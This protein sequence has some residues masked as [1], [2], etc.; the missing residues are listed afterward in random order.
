MRAALGFS[1]ACGLALL[2]GGAM[3]ENETG[4]ALTLFTDAIR[5]VASA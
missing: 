1:L 4:L 3:I 5:A 2:V